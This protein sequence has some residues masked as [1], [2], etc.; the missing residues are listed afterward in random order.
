MKKKI[1]IGVAGGLAGIAAGAGIGIGILLPKANK[2]KDLLENFA[3]TDGGK[4]VNISKKE[5]LNYVAIGDSETAGYNGFM[6]KDYVSFADFM[7]E[8]LR[9]ANRLG[10][11]KN[12]AKSGDTLFDTS[13]KT[14]YSPSNINALKDADIITITDGA[15]DLMRFMKFLQMGFP[16]GNGLLGGGTMNPF[17]ELFRKFA[18][19]GISHSDVWALADRSIKQLNDA[20]KNNDY[21]GVISIQKSLM[22]TALNLIKRHY[23]LLTHTLSSIAPNAQMVVLTHAFPFENLPNSL[24]N[25][26]QENLGGINLM[27][28]WAKFKKVIK[29]ST[30]P[31][32]QVMFVEADQ[33]PEYANNKDPLIFKDGTRPVSLNG[34]PVLRKMPNAGDIHP[35]TFGH[36]LL[37]NGLFH[38]LSK[39]FGIENPTSH[40]SHGRPADADDLAEIMDVTTAGKE[41]YSPEYFDESNSTTLNR[42]YDEMVRKLLTNPGKDV[43]YSLV[44][45]LKDIMDMFVGGDESE[46][47]IFSIGSDDK[48]M[49]GVENTKNNEPESHS[50][51]TNGQGIMEFVFSNKDKNFEYAL[52]RLSAILGA[53]SMNFTKNVS[54]DPAHPEMLGEYIS[55]TLQEFANANLLDSKTLPGMNLF[56]RRWGEANTEKRMGGY[57]KELTVTTTTPVKPS[58]GAPG[59]PITTTNTIVFGDLSTAGAET[60]KRVNFTPGDASKTKQRIKF[61]RLDTDGTAQ[62]DSAGDVIYDTFDVDLSKYENLSSFFSHYKITDLMSQLLPLHVG[63]DS[64]LS[65]NNLVTGE[66]RL[67]ERFLSEFGG[68]YRKWMDE[69]YASFK[70]TVIESF[71][72]NVDYDVDELDREYKMAYDEI[73]AQN[74]AI[75]PN[76]YKTAKKMYDNIEA[77]AP[78][79]GHTW[80]DWQSFSIVFGDKVVQLLSAIGY[81]I[82]TTPLS[83]FNEKNYEDIKNLSPSV[84]AMLKDVSLEN[85]KELLLAWNDMR[86]V[87]EGS[88]YAMTS[89][90]YRVIRELNLQTDEQDPDTHVWEVKTKYKEFDKIYKYLHGIDNNN[91]DGSPSFDHVKSLLEIIE[92]RI[93]GDK[94]APTSTTPTGGGSTSTG[95]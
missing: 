9:K 61:V 10:F 44:S 79:Q 94:P 23:I 45:M 84:V 2:A 18:S 46:N 95:G 62:T 29:E 92:S 3:P 42:S 56:F 89:F 16:S 48:L 91:L 11:Y 58:G 15:N 77:V 86:A 85:F 14:M 26:K 70:E 71:N 82:N 47:N 74:V 13:D 50:I 78:G 69:G 73:K 40:F 52:G 28:Y 6:G 31:D 81:D 7:A 20:F 64:F 19:S 66:V 87:H 63:W 38:Y 59:T 33:I 75:Y 30:D 67:K 65:V 34:R 22:D 53:A 49:Q 17:R 72:D 43:T 88:L 57:T 8:D 12:F 27:D 83:E 90:E 21:A 37:G 5:R 41:I 32:A 4:S 24:L 36:E 54:D 93:T 68:L 35:S 76:A 55:R 51:L 25:G 39:T 1:A 60:I 80:I